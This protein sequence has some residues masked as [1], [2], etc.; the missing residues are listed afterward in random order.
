MRSTNLCPAVHTDESLH[1]L[2]TCHYRA[3]NKVSA[4]S[5]LRSHGCRLPQSRFLLARCCLDLRKFS[6][7]ELALDADTGLASRTSAKAGLDEVAGSF[8]DSASFALALVGQLCSR[9]ERSARAVE[10]FRCVAKK[11]WETCSLKSVK[12]SPK[13]FFCLWLVRWKNA[14]LGT[15]AAILGTELALNS[16]LF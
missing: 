5:L 4:Y 3:G 6:E 12:S 1:L 9:T 11:T 7:A 10:A 2:A 8:G 14:E 16:V 13:F 15:S